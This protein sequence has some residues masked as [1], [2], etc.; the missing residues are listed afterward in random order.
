MFSFYLAQGA[1]WGLMVG[2]VVGTVRMV[3][4][5]VYSTPSC[6]E[7]DLRPALMKDVHYLYFALILLALTALIITSVSLRTAPIPEQHVTINRNSNTYIQ[8]IIYIHFYTK[9]TK[10]RYPI[11]W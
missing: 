10:R 2:L 3:M 11:T 8:I 4:E 6:G 7:E 9:L 1:F 5:F